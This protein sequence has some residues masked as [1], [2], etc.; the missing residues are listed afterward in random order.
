MANCPFVKLAIF[1][2]DRLDR[3]HVRGHELIGRLEQ[4]IGAVSDVFLDSGDPTI[5]LDD[6]ASDSNVSPD[7]VTLEHEGRRGH[8]DDKHPSELCQSFVLG[9]HELH[10]L[11]GT[12]PCNVCRY[13]RASAISLNSSSSPVSS[14][15]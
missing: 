8:S 11:F 3:P 5:D 4:D 13:S 6:L 9:R 12:A 1:I 10:S 7:L 15:R 2:N 14:L